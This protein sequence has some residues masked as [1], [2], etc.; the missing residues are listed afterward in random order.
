MTI[1]RRAWLLAAGAMPLELAA[2]HALGA[3]VSQG[4]RAGDRLDSAGSPPPIGPAPSLP[5]KASFAHVRGTSLNAAATHPRPA[6]ATEFIR[7]SVAA[8]EA[9]PSG[10][11][12]PNET[13]IREMFATLVNVDASEVVLV[14]TT[15]AGESFVASALGVHERGSHVVSDYL[16]FV[17][18]QMMYTDM[19]KRGVEVTWVKMRDNAISLDDLDRAIVKGKTKLVAVSGTSFVNG[20]EHDLKRVSEIAHAKGAMVYADIIQTAGNSPLD[21]HASGVDAAATGTYKWLMSS[22]TAFLY[23]RKSSQERMRPPFYH[24]EQETTPLPTTHMYPFDAPGAQI[25]DHYGQKKGAAG[26]FAMGYEPNIATLAGLE[27]SLPYIMNIGVDNIQ[28]H[29]QRL[30]NRLKAEL[31][32][33]GYPLLTPLGARSPIVTVVAEN[34]ERLAPMLKAA[35]VNVTTRWNH[36]RIAPSVFNDMDDVDRF[37]AV[38]PRA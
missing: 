26:M 33:R 21:L 9:D 38:L 24:W 17:G 3:Q 6:G 37:L 10:M 2:I 13:R 7:K 34:A 1:T 16:H 5:D 29:A 20:F 14:P 30:T 19:A 36:I 11:Y 32:R 15:Q 35:N 4:T 25:V 22:G 28:A 8:E 31:P 12:R 18:S 27:Y 23:V